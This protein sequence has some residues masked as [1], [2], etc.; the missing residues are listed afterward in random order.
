MC[1]RD[2]TK[3]D[4][5]NKNIK[6]IHEKIDLI[7]K[8]LSQKADT[9][10]EETNKKMDSGFKNL[11]ET[12]NSTSEGTKE[13]QSA[14]LSEEKPNREKEKIM[15]IEIN[16]KGV[17]KQIIKKTKE[18]RIIR[19]NKRKNTREEVDMIKSGLVNVLNLPII[20]YRGLT[21]LKSYR[22]NL[23]KSIFKLNIPVNKRSVTSPV[24]DI[25]ST[26]LCNRLHIDMIEI[27]V[28]EEL[29]DMVVEEYAT[30]V[31]ERVRKT[32]VTIEFNENSISAELQLSLIHI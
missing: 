29:Q 5:S 14:L 30:N 4:G 16:I 1:I 6:Q 22:K 3:F 21:V 24:N 32:M 20:N 27:S 23:T 15:P 9:Y 26:Y 19:L 28:L 10:K 17:K 12:L 18:R 31:K 8:T 25:S 7:N 13:D 2:S 11:D